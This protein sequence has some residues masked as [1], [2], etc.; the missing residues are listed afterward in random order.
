MIFYYEYL[1]QYGDTREEIHKSIDYALKR[2]G[3][4]GGGQIFVAKQEEN[5][6]GDVIVNQTGMRGYIPE[7]ILVYIATHN[8]AVKVLEKN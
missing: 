4:Q 8:H 5:I 3:G 6:L 1:E 7:N 2:N